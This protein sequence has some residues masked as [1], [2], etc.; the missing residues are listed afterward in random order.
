MGLRD[1]KEFQAERQHVQRTDA[2][3]RDKWYMW[4]WQQRDENT[5]AERAKPLRT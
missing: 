4:P 3:S 5:P 1:K 2:K